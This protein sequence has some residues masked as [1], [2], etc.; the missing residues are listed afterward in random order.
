MLEAL[1]GSSAAACT[2]ADY[3]LASTSYPHFCQLVADFRAMNDYGYASDELGGGAL[4]DEEVWE[5]PHKNN[6]K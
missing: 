1:A 4:E 5:E 3:L 2:C 6:R